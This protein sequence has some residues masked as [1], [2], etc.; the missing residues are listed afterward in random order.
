MFL[1]TEMFDFRTI[2]IKSLNNIQTEIADDIKC[3]KQSIKIAVSWLTDTLLINEL[4]CARKRGIDIK[5]IVSS[6]ELNIIRFEL[7]QILLS[8]GAVVNKEGNKDA[9]QGNFM[10][11]KFYIVDDKYAKSGSYNWS[12]NAT[13]NK[14]TLDE[15]SVT[16]KIKQFNECYESSVNFFSDIY[17]PVKNKDEITLIENE[18]KNT[19]TSEI[20]TAYKRTQI[21]IKHP[22]KRDNEELIKFLRSIPKKSRQVISEITIKK[23]DFLKE[24]GSSEPIK[25][26]GNGYKFISSN[27]G[28][29][30]WFSADDIVKIISAEMLVIQHLA[31]REGV[32]GSK[33]MYLV[34]AI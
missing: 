26:N 17:Y 12:A 32:D 20:L 23:A 8:L 19:L 5:I 24:I 27:G 11:Y 3:A 15:V 13:T 29:D 14:E 22:E 18:Y 33:E 25:T 1:R 16:K 31:A 9:E 7:F 21:S 28:P 6:N 30:F 10:H 4:I 34:R 2:N